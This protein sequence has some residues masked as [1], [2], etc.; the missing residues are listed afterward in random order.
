MRFLKLGGLSLLFMAAALG[1]YIGWLHAT[2]N[3]HTVIAGE[4][5]RSAQPTARDVDR[6]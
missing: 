6:Y 5:Y 1:A 2:G 3:F 4:L